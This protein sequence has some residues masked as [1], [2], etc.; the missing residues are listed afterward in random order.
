MF[1][2]S[3]LDYL[4]ILVLQIFACKLNMFSHQNVSLNI[5]NVRISDIDENFTVFIH[6]LC[7]LRCNV[8]II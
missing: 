7:N 6:V 4:H 8:F 1:S 2:I 5:D 3:I